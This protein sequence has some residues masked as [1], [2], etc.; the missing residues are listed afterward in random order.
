MY[1][2]K[3]SHERAFEVCFATAI[4][5]PVAYWEKIGPMR[6]KRGVMLWAKGTNQ[7]SQD[8]NYAPRLT[9]RAVK[10]EQRPIAPEEFSLPP[11][12]KKVPSI[13]DLGTR[14]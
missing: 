13:R 6:P 8:V 7:F 9:L 4:F 3:G 2:G 11:G 14:P 5:M 10:I 1:S 12:Y